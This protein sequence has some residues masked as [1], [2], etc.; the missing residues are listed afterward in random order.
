MMNMTRDALAD[1]LIT[2]IK[3]DTDI[4]ISAPPITFKINHTLLR[5]ANAELANALAFSNT[6]D[7]DHEFYFSD[8]QFDDLS[9]P[10]NIISDCNDFLIAYL[11]SDNDA[12]IDCIPSMIDN[13][14]YLF[15]Y[16]IFN[17]DDDDEMPEYEFS[18]ADDLLALL[19]NEFKI[20]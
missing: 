18:S 19:R 20:A 6:P 2:A 13:I 15:S 3:N 14:D 9:N 5:I 1:A 7:F 17:D 12:M 16:S 4:P 8:S 10:A 11:E